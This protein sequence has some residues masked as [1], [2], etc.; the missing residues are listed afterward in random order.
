[1]D[2]IIG[3][4]ENVLYIEPFYAGDYAHEAVISNETKKDLLERGV[5]EYP[6]YD[7]VLAILHGLSYEDYLEMMSRPTEATEKGDSNLPF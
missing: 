5:V 4:V 7:Y 1:M 3:I 6:N 2:R